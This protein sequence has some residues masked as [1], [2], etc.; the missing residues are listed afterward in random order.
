MAK[1]HYSL[2]DAL[3]IELH[4]SARPIV[5]NAFRID[6]DELMRDGCVRPRC[7]SRFTMI[8]QRSLR[9]G[10]DCESLVTEPWRVGFGSDTPS[11]TPGRT[12]HSTLTTALI[13]RPPDPRSEGCGGGLSDR[14]QIGACARYVFRLV[15][16]IFGLAGPI[17]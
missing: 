9:P 3:W 1:K 13:W 12:K 5:E 10:Y 2:R 11:T 14:P 8:F 15:G 7:R 17:V 4:T 6:L 16:T